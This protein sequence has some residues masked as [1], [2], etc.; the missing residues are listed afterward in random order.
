MELYLLPPVV[1]LDMLVQVDSAEPK[2]VE[3]YSMLYYPCWKIHSGTTFLPHFAY[4]LT[5][6]EP[7]Q[8]LARFIL[9]R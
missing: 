1:Y 9:D 4:M 8:F 5:D 2:L 3:A 6:V 7:A